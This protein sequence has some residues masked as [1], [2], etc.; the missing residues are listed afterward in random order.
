MD[1]GRSWRCLAPIQALE[2]GDEADDWGPHGSER[3]CGAWLSKRKR[4]K[5]G[6]GRKDFDMSWLNGRQRVRLA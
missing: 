3:S 5:Q 1:G 2:V 4:E 6:R